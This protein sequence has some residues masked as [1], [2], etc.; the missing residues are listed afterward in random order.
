MKTS[1][2]R[3]LIKKY[4]APALHELGF[5]GTDHHF[6]RVAPNHLVNTIVIQADKDGVSCV[7]EMG[8][9]DCRSK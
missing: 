1:D 3:N 5:S 6:V 8:V 9:H 4:L 7:V 2:F